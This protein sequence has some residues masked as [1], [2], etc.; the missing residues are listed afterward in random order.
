VKSTRKTWGPFSGPQLTTIVCVIVAA[1]MFPAGAWA[2]VSFS[3]VAI[4]DPGGV[5]RAKVDTTGKLAV[6]DGSGPLTV[7]GTVGSRQSLPAKPIV[8][9]T[10]DIGNA[11]TKIYGP[12]AA[13]FGISSLTVTNGC[14]TATLFGIDSV[15]SNGGKFS[16]QVALIPPMQTTQFTYPSMLVTTPPAGGTAS[17]QASATDSCAI[18]NG[19]GVQS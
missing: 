12:V 6:G 9:V 2:A 4:T 10:T 1:V 16:I 3:N 17:L 19:V 8:I 18:V 14:S 11:F 13:P 5:N 15:T 7:D